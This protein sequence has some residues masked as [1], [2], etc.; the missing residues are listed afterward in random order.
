MTHSIVEAWQ[1]QNL[2]GEAGSLKSEEG[3]AVWVQRQSAGEPGRAD[4]ADK[5]QRQSSGKISSYS[6]E[7][8]L[9]FYSDLQLIG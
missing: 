4:V 7:V 3:L 6:R 5:D 1:V 8:S 2:M 9:L